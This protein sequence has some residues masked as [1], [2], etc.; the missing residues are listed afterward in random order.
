MLQNAAA[1]LLTG[2]R[3]QDHMTPILCTLHWLPVR[4]RIDYKILLFVCK[5]LNNLAP[6]YLSDLLTTYNPARSLRSQVGHLLRIPQSCLQHR[7]D[8]A[9]AVA[10]P[11]LSNSLPLSVRTASTLAKFKSRLKMHFSCAFNF[12]GLVSCNAVYA[13]SESSRIS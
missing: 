9:F 8:R 3:K 10:G 13:G 2:S 1:R 11:K 6:L 12:L 4:Y 5:A 7:G